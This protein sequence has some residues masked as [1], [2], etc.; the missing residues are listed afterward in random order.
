MGVSI[1]VLSSKHVDALRALLVREP[2]HNLYLLGLLE[3]FGIASGAGRPPHT[4]HG[5]FVDGELTAVLF[6]GGNGGALVPSASPPNTIADI[7]RALG[8]SIKP[9]SIL[10]DKPAVDVLAQHLCPTSKPRLSKNQRLFAVSADDLG[11]FTNPTLRLAAD[12]DLT[13]LLP[14]AAAAVKELV[15]RDPLVED[16]RGFQERVRAKVKMRRTWV[17]EDKDKRLV[18][19][20]DVGSRSAYGA[21]LEGLYTVPDQRRLGHATLSLGQISRQMLS[22]LPRLTLRVDDNNSQL[23]G[24]ARKVGFL[25]GRAQR[26]VVF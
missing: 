20:I 7:A 10:G 9:L 13:Q 24:L 3:D 22:S 1:E 5:R 14:M 8:A 25:A 4:F 23:G 6:V 19:K 26:I 21:E 15:D 12:A 17:L 16:P 2:A 11:P 18:F